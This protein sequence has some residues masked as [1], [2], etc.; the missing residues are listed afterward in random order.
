MLR[1]DDYIPKPFDLDHLY[2]TLRKYVSENILKEMVTDVLKKTALG[3]KG[4]HKAT[5]LKNWCV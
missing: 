5:P 4:P 2:H 1:F 3:K